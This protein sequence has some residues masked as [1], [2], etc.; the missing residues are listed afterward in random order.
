MEAE[1]FNRAKS[2][3]VQAQSSEPQSCFPKP[4]NSMTVALCR[5][6]QSVSRPMY[7]AMVPRDSLS[8]CE[9]RTQG[10]PHGRPKTGSVCPH[11]FATRMCTLC[12]AR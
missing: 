7:A 8:T 6:R 5:S 10:R 4:C 9:R 3:L 1:L 12:P 2:V 11:A